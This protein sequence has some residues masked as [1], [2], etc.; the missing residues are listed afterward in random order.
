MD[1]YFLGLS[2]LLSCNTFATNLWQGGRLKAYLKAQ[3]HSI[4]QLMLTCLFYVTYSNKFSG[5]TSDDSQLQ[6]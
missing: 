6:K 1:F 2:P 3:L 5:Y 4:S